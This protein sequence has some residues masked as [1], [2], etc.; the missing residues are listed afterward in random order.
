MWPGRA[1]CPERIP[2]GARA[3]IRPVSSLM[4]RLRQVHSGHVGDYVGWLLVGV[5]ALA[6]LVGLPLR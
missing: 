1:L 4:R 2:D 6:A 5:A 3:G